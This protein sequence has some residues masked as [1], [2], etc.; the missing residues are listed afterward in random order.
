MR[1]SL[2]VTTVVVAVLGL[3]FV[4]SMDDDPPHDSHLVLTEGTMPT[5]GNGFLVLAESLDAMDWPEDDAW[6]QAL[7]GR[8]IASSVDILALVARNR[9][10][11]ALVAAAANAP[12]FQVPNSAD[13]DAPGL[14]EMHHMGQ[15]VALDATMR[16]SHGD[17]FE[18][19]RLHL[20]LVQQLKSRGQVIHYLIGR[21]SQAAM[22]QHILRFA[23]GL[24][25]QGLELPAN[26]VLDDVWDREAM[27]NTLRRDY[28]LMTS[29]TDESFNP[30]GG[31]IGRYTYQPNRTRKLYA[32]SFTAAIEGLGE[33]CSTA[34]R[35]SARAT[36][37][38]WRY[39]GPNSNGRI[40]HNIGV[41][42]LG[43]F[44][45]SRCR[46]QMTIGLTRLALATRAYRAEAGEL[47]ES[48]AALVPD[49]LAELPLDV[50][51]QAFRYSPSAEYLYSVGDDRLDDGGGE[52][53]LRVDWSAP[54]PG[55]SL[56][57]E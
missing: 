1:T 50:D 42:F 38:K 13:S 17:A 19:L 32:D 8:E 20:A 18:R 45:F 53:T 15:L 31:W 16:M 49:Y 36:I 35:E 33:D 28:M 37:S 57:R 2:L 27:A 43:K 4:L 22:L 56:R 29:M 51:G 24:D 26:G 10:A 23:A 9:D 52:P 54:D 3:L 46:E 21:S 40:V 12:S 7:P 25:E 34:P 47:P 6:V 14:I 48:L 41:S 39:L 5:E 30:V 44:T 11:L 55:V